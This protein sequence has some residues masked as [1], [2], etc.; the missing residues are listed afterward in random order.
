MGIG[1]GEVALTAGTG[2]LSSLVGGVRFLGTAIQNQVADFGLDASGRIKGIDRAR[3]AFDAAVA[4]GT[5]QPRSEQG[6]RLT[7]AVMAPVEAWG[8]GSNIAGANVARRTG[9]P[10]AGAA[11]NALLQLAPVTLGRA[12]VRNAVGRTA[13]VYSD[14]W[15]ATTPEGRLVNPRPLLSEGTPDPYAL[16]P[17]ELTLP[18][19]PPRP[20]AFPPPNP[21]RAAARVEEAPIPRP[22]RAAR[23]T[24]RVARTLVE[25]LTRTGPEDAAMRLL[26]RFGFKPDDFEGLTSQPTATGALRTLPEQVASPEGA[27]AAA[28]LMDT[29]RLDPDQYV[30]ISARDAANNAARIDKLAE[31]AG[32]GGARAQAEVLRQETTSPIYERALSVEINPAALPESQLAYLA[33]LFERPA[34][35]RALADGAENLRNEGIEG[36]AR[37]SM[38]A[39]HAAK[40]AL[41]QRILKAPANPAETMSIASMR[42]ARE[43]LV[44]SIEQLSPEYATARQEFARLSQPINQMDLAGTILDRGTVATPSVAPNASTI[45]VLSAAQLGDLTAPRNQG[46][47]IT[48]AIG[49]SGARSFEDIMTPD[50][51]QM[52]NAIVAEVQRKAAV[53]KA[54]SGPGSATA[55]RLLSNNILQAMDIDNPSP[56]VTTAIDRISGLANMVTGSDM[57]L[58]AAVA[59]LILNPGKARAAFERATPKRQAQRKA[60]NPPQ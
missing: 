30:S 42:K 48:A 55:Q 40:V 11:T 34:I 4:G 32:R 57:K 47:T 1:A 53:E 29:S 45:P 6:R 12:P 10:A 18:P 22:V 51:L 9:S 17:P 39:L 2:A 27:T 50:Q 38:R 44:R 7:G 15:A 14:A 36:D 3:A 8:E 5:Y 26:A 33:A 25:P 54:A 43:A 41:D 19:P 23:A 21:A 58:R 20:S 35:K 56:A 31:L 13:Q 59:D 24:Q 60:N 49:R 52:L 28:R 46:K 16:P 37:Y